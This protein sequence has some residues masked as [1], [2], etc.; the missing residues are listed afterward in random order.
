MRFVLLS[1]ALAAPNPTQELATSLQQE[2]PSFAKKTTLCVSKELVSR[3]G[4]AR[5]RDALADHADEVP[6]DIKTATLQAFSACSAWGEVMAGAFAERGVVVS[7]KSRKCMI[8]AFSGM[9]DV[10]SRAVGLVVSEEEVAEADKTAMGM[11]LLGCL[12]ADEL[13]KMS[14][15]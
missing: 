6:E 4:D 1:I 3:L 7:A 15:G 8:K 14:G 10:V 5:A 9:G 13:A 2:F 11:T 12:S